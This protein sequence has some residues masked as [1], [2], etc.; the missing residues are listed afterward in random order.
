M[1]MHT[2]GSACIDLQIDRFS[3]REKLK[4]RVVVNIGSFGKTR[5]LLDEPGE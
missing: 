1:F 4:R 3:L 2:E 5:K